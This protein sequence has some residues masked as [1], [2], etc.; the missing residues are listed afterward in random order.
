MFKTILKTIALSATALTFLSACGLTDAIYEA[1]RQAGLNGPGS[2]SSGFRDGGG[3]YP[4]VLPESVEGLVLNRSA[5][6]APPPPHPS[7]LDPT[8]FNM[9]AARVASFSVVGDIDDG[10]TRGY[11]HFGRGESIDFDDDT[12][13]IIRS[14]TQD[15]FSLVKNEGA[16]KNLIMIVNGVEYKVRQIAY[17]PNH[18]NRD[19]ATRFYN[20]PIRTGVAVHA[21]GNIK[22]IIRGTH[23]TIQGDYIQYFTNTNVDGNYLDS[24]TED[25]TTGYATIGIQTPV[26]VVDAQTAVAIYSGTSYLYTHAVDGLDTVSSW[27]NPDITM[28][29]NFD[30]NTVS[31]SGNS[32]YFG[33]GIEFGLAPIVGNGFEGTFTLNSRA[34]EWFNLTDNPTGQYSGNFFGPNADD[35]AGVMSFESKG[36]YDT[37]FIK[38]PARD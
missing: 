25:Y 32:Q 6:S 23:A 19:V 20:D 33:G 38:A 31:G 30:E 37:G 3:Y 15:T 27:I 12:H 26:P 16:D 29:V 14:R 28:Y 18:A 22:E 35:L 8:P 34:R 4:A 7:D 13:N 9:V 10:G 5:E 1:G 17:D 21:N 24:R 11:Y 2:E 36:A